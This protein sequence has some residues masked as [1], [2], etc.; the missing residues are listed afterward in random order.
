MPWSLVLIIVGFVLMRSFWLW[1]EKS[2]QERK[3]QGKP[4]FLRP[5]IIAVGGGMVLLI[6]WAVATGN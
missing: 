1:A 6:L 5:I 2:G 3:E 4:N